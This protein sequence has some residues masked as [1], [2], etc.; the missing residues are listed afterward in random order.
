LLGLL[1]TDSDHRIV[2]QGNCRGSH[3]EHPLGRW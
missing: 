3:Q 1:R 2:A